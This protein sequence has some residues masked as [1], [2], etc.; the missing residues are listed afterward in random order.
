MY[1]HI[2]TKKQYNHQW[3]L[4]T[5]NKLSHESRDNSFLLEEWGNVLRMICTC[6]GISHISLCIQAKLWGADC[7]WEN[8]VYPL[9]SPDLYVNRSDNSL[10]LIQEIPQTTYFFYLFFYR[11][12]VACRKAHTY[13][14][15]SSCSPERSRRL[16]LGP[17]RVCV[18]STEI[19]S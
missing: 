15:V 3:Y 16:L 2:D 12:R 9:N 13:S 8:S 5:S 7:V 19:C 10:L 11:T 17:W 1:L 4:S 18:S 6:W 14:P